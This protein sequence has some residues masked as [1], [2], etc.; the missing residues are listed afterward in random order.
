MDVPVVRQQ[1]IARPQLIGAALD[2]IQHIPGHEKEDFVKF[3]LMEI[4]HRG[5]RVAVV[6]AFKV[7]LLHSLAQSK[8]V[9]M[10]IHQ[11]PPPILMHI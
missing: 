6:V 11:K 2:R 8:F 7:R 1:D 4:H 9:P 10:Q 3:V 5:N